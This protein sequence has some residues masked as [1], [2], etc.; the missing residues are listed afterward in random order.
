[1]AVMFNGAL[2]ALFN[3]TLDGALVVPSV[4]VENVM[5]EEDRLACGADPVPVSET[6][7]G[8]PAALSLT[9]SVVAKLPPVD[10]SKVTEILQLPPAASVDEHV[11]V[12]V[13]ADDPVPPPIE[14][15][16]PV[17]LALPGFDRVT[18]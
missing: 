3:V 9:L 7:C 2:P 10:G 15:A 5:L 6:V 4:V 17:R 8:E 13:N 1:M 16:I 18:D 12:S 14:M 11:V